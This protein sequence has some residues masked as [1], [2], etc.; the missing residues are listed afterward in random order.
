MA[1]IVCWNP[2]WIILSMTSIYPSNIYWKRY[3]NEYCPQILWVFC[4]VPFR[5]PHIFKFIVTFLRCPDFRST[6][7]TLFCLQLCSKVRFTKLIFLWH[8]VNAINFLLYF[9]FW[10]P[11]RGTSFIF[12]SSFFDFGLGLSFIGLFFL[13]L[14]RGDLKI[15]LGNC[16]ELS[17]GKSYAWS[18][19]SERTT[20]FWT[21]NR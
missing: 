19:R 21:A 20:F 9:C 8:W 1:G 13:A 15:H 2:C 11:E 5:Y 6:S 3:G 18:P 16:P 17:G 7:N 12:P 10:T 14:K 4:F